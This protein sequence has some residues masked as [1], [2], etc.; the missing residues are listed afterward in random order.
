MT[1][2]RAVSL[3]ARRELR[4]RLRSRAF[5]ASVA[6]QLAIVLVIVAVSALSG[7]DGPQSYEVGV[8]GAAATQL[9]NGL[10]SQSSPDFT[11]GAEDVEGEAAAREQVAGG[12][13]DAA[14]VDERLIVGPDTDEQLSALIQE[15]AARSESTSAL[16][17]EGLDQADINRALNP[18][19]LPTLE[20]GQDEASAEGI[21]FVGSL[22][23]YLGILGFGYVVTSGIVEEKASRVVELILSTIRPSQLLAGKVIGIGLLGLLQLALTAGVGLAAAVLSGQIDLPSTTPQTIALVLL[24]FVL[25]YALYACAFAVAGA[26]VSRQEDVGS[27]TTPIT[28]VLVAGYLA[29]FSVTDDPGGAL[30]TICTFLPPVAPLVVPARAA[31]DGL[32]AAELAASI[33]LMVAATLALIWLAARIYE[34]AVLRA[35]APMKLLEG[36]KLVRSDAAG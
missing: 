7:D 29:S 14:V 32:P 17:R 12:E 27:V 2:R 30:A 21:A 35:G 4:E 10:A 8:S 36:L 23:L 11:I 18:P 31:V 15:A 16:E 34:R 3:T 28:I 22:L 6:L 9:V 33:A 26:I 25:G 1:P 19:A 20:V 13:L 24:Y 5:R